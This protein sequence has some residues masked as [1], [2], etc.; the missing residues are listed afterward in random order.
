MAP[1]TDRSGAAPLLREG[2]SGDWD[3][4]ERLYVEALVEGHRYGEAEA[5][6][7]VRARRERWQQPDAYALVA[8]DAGRPLG[9]VWVIRDVFAAGCD[10][11]QLVATDGRQRRRGVATALL[12]AAVARSTERGRRGLR[13][14]VYHANRPSLRLFESLGFREEDPKAE[15]VMVSLPLGPAAASPA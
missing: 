5:V 2:V 10:Y 1:D 8:A 11:V 4:V 3:F 7:H 12:R 6:Q 13:A 14:G 15:L 9:V